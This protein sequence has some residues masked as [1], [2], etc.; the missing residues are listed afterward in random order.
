MV[1][2]LFNDSQHLKIWIFSHKF[3][4]FRL[5][6]RPLIP[7]KH[8][9]ARLEITIPF[10]WNAPSPV[11]KKKK[12]RRGAGSQILSEFPSK[13]KNMSHYNHEEVI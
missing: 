4:A 9:S 8:Q 10:R 13:S 3:S 6:H 7:T 1:F 5:P 12:L 2:N 11:R